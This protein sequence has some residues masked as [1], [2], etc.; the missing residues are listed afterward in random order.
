MNDFGIFA[1]NVFVVFHLVA[2][3]EILNVTSLLK[4]DGKKTNL[5][6]ILLSYSME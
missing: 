3:S 6:F 4:K 2:T 1:T 5:S